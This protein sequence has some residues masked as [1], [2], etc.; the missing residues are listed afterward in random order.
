MH[1][2]ISDSVYCPIEEEYYSRNSFLVD[3]TEQF[4]PPNIKFALSIFDSDLW[5]SYDYKSNELFNNRRED[6]LN[7]LNNLDCANDKSPDISHGINIEHILVSGVSNNMLNNNNVNKI[8]IL[9]HCNIETEERIGTSVF[10]DFE[11][12]FANIYTC[13][14]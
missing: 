8:F 14:Y 3:W 10:E 5:I 12:T 2:N 4:Y 13:W 7:I 9:S 6:I 1:L 11:I